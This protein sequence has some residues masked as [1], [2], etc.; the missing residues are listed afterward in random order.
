MATRH[1]RGRQQDLRQRVPR[2]PRPEPRGRGRRVPGAGRAVG[3]RQVDGAAHDRRARD[4]H[5]RASCTSAT[6]VVNDVDPKDRDIAMVFQNYALYPHMTVRDNIGVRARSCA[7]SPRTRSTERVRRRR[8]TILELTENLDRKPGAA[9]RR[10]APAGRDG[11]RDRSPAA[12]LPDGRAALE[13]RRQAARPD[14]RRDRARCSASSDVTTHL[15]HPR[16]GRGHDDGRPGRACSRAASSSRSTRRRT[17]TTI[18]TTCS[19]PASSARR[20]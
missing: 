8:P 15:R 4:D 16:P 14:A 12:G 19:S 5:R 18:R 6:G 20:R 10:P 1:A 11:P 13:P 9:L 3:L 2:R 17:S 7:R